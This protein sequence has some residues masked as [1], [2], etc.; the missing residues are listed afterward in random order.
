M[1][2]LFSLSILDTHGQEQNSLLMK[3]LHQC[4]ILFDFDD[5]MMDIKS[6]EVKRLALNEI[7][8]FLGNPKTLLPESAYHE[9]IRMVRWIF[10]HN[11]SYMIH[12]EHLW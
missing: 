1:N 11:T 8:E 5:P 3:K 7:I 6:K 12:H 9:I 2:E 10:K 4:S